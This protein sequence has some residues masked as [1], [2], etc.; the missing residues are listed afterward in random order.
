MKCKQ[1]DDLLFSY[2]DRQDIPPRLRQEL[3]EHL[4]ECPECRKAAEFTA[5]EREALVYDGDIPEMSPDLVKRVL[6]AVTQDNAT[7]AP[8][9]MMPIYSQIGSRGWWA[10]GMVAAVV[11]IL[12]ILPGSYKNPVE[13]LNTGQQL[14]DSGEQN[15]P[16]VAEKRLEQEKIP[17][18]VPAAIEYYYMDH[19]LDSV[20]IGRGGQSSSAA[21]T[22]GN[23]TTSNQ[24]AVFSPSYLPSDYHLVRVESDLNDN[25]TIYYEN[26][27]DGYICLKTIP[28]LEEDMNVGEENARTASIYGK[29][30]DKQDNKKTADQSD[31]TVISWTTEHEGTLYRFELTGS[32]PPEELARVAASVE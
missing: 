20:Q 19:G 16:M 25:I 26:D 17:A 2:C 31:P 15:A 14:A 11:I 9:K 22:T 3:E 6:A 12:L 32:L 1:V 28:G 21:P 5:R 10:M 30:D 13:S 24:S 4:K 18:K 23:G 8:S 27:E 7:L 29:T